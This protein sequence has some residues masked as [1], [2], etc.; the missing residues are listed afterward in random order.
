M[1]ISEEDKNKTIVAGDYWLR[2]HGIVTDVTHNTLIRSIRVYFD[3]VKHL[4]YFIST[5]QQFLIMTIYLKFSLFDLIK[6]IFKK[7]N[8]V[9]EVLDFTRKYLPTYEVFVDAKR[10]KKG[11]EHQKIELFKKSEEKEETS[12]EQKES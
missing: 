10:Y 7:D 5:E 2:E 12:E 8:T 9:T 1:N 4:E 11:V 6:S 3:K